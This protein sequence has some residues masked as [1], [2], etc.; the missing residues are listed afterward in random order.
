MEV[1]MAAFRCASCGSLNR[2]DPTR[3]VPA[4]C[5]KCKAAL[6]ETNPPFYVDD[7]AL[8]NLVASSPVP[9]LVDFYADWCAPCRSLAPTLAELAKANAGKILVAKVDTDVNGRTAGSLGVQGIPALFLY[10]D[11]QVVAQTAGARPLSMLQAFVGPH[12]Q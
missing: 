3:A 10:R 4:K 2:V 11:G 1:E 12:I 7:D 9:V 5:G 8:A 6:D